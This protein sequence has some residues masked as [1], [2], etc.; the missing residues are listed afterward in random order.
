[1]WNKLFCRYLNSIIFP[2]KLLEKFKYNIILCSNGKD[3]LFENIE[4]NKKAKD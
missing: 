3:M 4:N 2:L 1:M